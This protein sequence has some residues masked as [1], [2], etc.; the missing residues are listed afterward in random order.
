M[1]AYV[2]YR[3]V[4]Q[5]RVLEAS[6]LQKLLRLLVGL[7][8]GGSV[9]LLASQ[10]IAQEMDGHISSLVEKLS[11]N[12]RVF[13]VSTYDLSLE[14]ARTLAREDI[15]YLYVDMEHGPMDF[16]AL[17]TF[18][19]GMTDR[20][21]ILDNGHLRQRVTPLARIAP[22]GRETPEWAVK[23]ALDVGLMGLIFPSIETPE[24]A[25]RA[26]RA[27]RYPQRQGGPY[28]EPQGLRGS[29]PA[30]ATWLWGMTGADYVRHAD[31][32]PL[33]PNGD[34]VAFMMIE[35]RTGVRNADAIAQVPG[36]AGFYIGPSD[37]SNSLGV[38]RNNAEVEEAIQTVVDVCRVRDIACG[39]TASAAD[40]SRRIA[41]GFTVLGAGRAGG[42]LSAGNQA[43]VQAGR[44]VDN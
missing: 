3:R 19:L 14:N 4:I 15:D 20:K 25:L 16:A 33:N 44:A 7:C 6:M 11:R 1:A 23:Q 12:E 42:G 29:G 26:V 2:S 5:S 13:G 39:I 31:L 34:L 43:A 40:M 8:M 18:L 22:Y 37:L 41:Q 24:Q 36:V 21:A 28:M 30:I 17:Q 9:A 27:M 32:W 35:S 10:S 38:D